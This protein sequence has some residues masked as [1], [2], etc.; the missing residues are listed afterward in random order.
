M[1]Q[2]QPV[3]DH[4][5]GEGATSGAEAL[6]PHDQFTVVFEGNLRDIKRNPFMT[7]T[8]F[9]LPRHVGVGN[10]FEE[11]DEFCAI[12]DQLLE[13]LI[14][15]VRVADRKTDEFDAARAAISKATGQTATPENNH[16]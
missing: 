12:R 10:A 4:A 6:P 16:D 3:A 8:P 15:V 7:K 11:F 14:G 2:S 5:S 13:A 1:S 9:G